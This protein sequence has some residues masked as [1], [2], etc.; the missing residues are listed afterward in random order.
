[1]SDEDRDQRQRLEGRV[2]FRGPEPEALVGELDQSTAAK[3]DGEES[4]QR[5]P[6]A[7]PSELFHTPIMLSNESPPQG[8]HCLVA[9]FRR[10]RRAFRFHTRFCM[11][12][13]AQPAK[14]MP[15]M[16]TRS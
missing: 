8:R 6:P 9:S 14:T 2:S 10:R 15:M 12:S 16:F 3:H 13:V 1:M 7:L 4:Q 5:I 11:A